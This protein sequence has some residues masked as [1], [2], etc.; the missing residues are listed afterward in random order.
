MARNGSGTYSRV[1]GPYAYDT[2][3]SETDV[4][5]EMDDI[6]TALTA[7]LAKD[8]QTTPTANLPMGGFRH[9]GAANGSART[10]YATMGQAQDGKINWVDSGGTADAITATYSPAITALVDG[11]VCFVRAGAANATTTPT[12]SPNS[13]TAR[14]IVKEGGQ[15]LVAGDIR[16]DGHELILRYDLTNT[17]W[18]LLNPARNLPA[19]SASASG[20]VELAT[21]AETETGTDATRAVTP[22]GLHD[23]TTLAGKAWFLDED[24]MASNSAV[25]TA[26]QQS[27]KAYADTKATIATG[28]SATDD[29][30]AVGTTTT[31]A[32][33][34]SGVPNLV[35]L[36]LVCLT[37]DL[38]YS[39]GETVILGP[40]FMGNG[41]TVSGIT[42]EVDATNVKIHTAASNAPYIVNKSTFAW[43]QITVANWKIMADCYRIA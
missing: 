6:A 21:T 22:D 14:T 5:A 27:I 25:K 11:Q 32:H 28:T 38:G 37:A 23:M 13:L 4:N 19:A 30:Y 20:I 1:A 3:I 42:V 31:Q 26:S 36:K 41:G 16:G 15:A 33:G 34:L 7:S 24:N 29:P 12:F 2:V 8:G 39:T 40:S 9:T 17:R 35:V 18:E 43:G 10:D